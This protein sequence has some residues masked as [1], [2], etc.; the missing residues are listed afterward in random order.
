[1]EII[2]LSL[3]CHHQNDSCIKMGSNESHFNVSL[4]VRDKSDQ[5]PRTRF[6]RPFHTTLDHALGLAVN[7][8]VSCTRVFSTVAESAECPG[9]WTRYG[10]SCF[11]ILKDFVNWYEGKVACDTIDGKLVKIED[12][13]QNNFIHNLLQSNQG[14]Y[15]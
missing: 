11:V 3:H 12:A 10:S 1:M 5:M 13:D 8:N 7:A 15:K 4:I 6:Y 2:Y 9:G 14:N